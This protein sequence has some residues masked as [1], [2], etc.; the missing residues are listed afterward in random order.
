MTSRQT[1]R[2]ACELEGGY[3]HLCGRANYVRHDDDETA[4]V[5]SCDAETGCPHALRL[6]ALAKAG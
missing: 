2:A 6:E 4:R 5:V 1:V 3:P